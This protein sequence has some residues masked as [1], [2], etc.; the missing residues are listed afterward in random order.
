M[1][2]PF[3]S[4]EFHIHW[5]LLVPGAIEADITLALKRAAEAVEA[6][7][8]TPSG[9]ETFE[10]TVLALE[11]ALLELNRA[12]AKVEHINSVNNTP[13][14]REVHARMLPQ[15]S[16]FAT[17]VLLNAGVWRA[18]TAFA[19]SPRAASLDAPS[20]RL[21]EETLACF[22]NNGANLPAAAKERLA[23]IN[24][25]LARLTQQYAENVLDATNA[26]AKTV[27]DEALLAGLPE[28]AKAAALAEAAA[29]GETR[30]WRFTLRAPSLV[31]VLQYA[32]DETFRRECWEASANVAN[33]GANDNTRLV[34]QILDLR[35][36]KARLLGKENFADFTTV[37]RMA[38]S[39][40]NALRFV[41][42]LH[43]RVRK[44][45]ER[46]T[47][48]LENFKAAKTATPAAPLAPWEITYWAEKQRREEH[49]FD[50]EA[51]RPYLPLDDVTRGMFTLFGQLFGIRISPR[52]T[53]FTDPDTG[54]REI[55]SAGESDAA[56]SPVETWHP[57]VK[58]YEAFDSSDG[59]H[60]GSFYT[61]WHPRET[62][63]AGAWM[64]FFPTEGICHDGAPAPRL[65]LMCGNF[66]PP[67]DNAQ[68]LLSHDE[69]LTLF[70]EFGH[71]LHHILSTVPFESLGGT[72]V[73]WDFVELPSQLLE[74]WCWH[75]EGLNHFARHH[76]TGEPLPEELLKA[77][78]RASNFRAASATMRQLSL[79]KL[80]L[81]LHIHLAQ[82]RGRD[83]D[84]IWNNY[85][86][87]YQIRTSVPTPSMARRFTHIFGDPT[88]YAAGYYSYKW[89]E[90][91]EAD[92]FTR[93]LKEGLLNK[94][95]GRELREKIYS[96]GNLEPPEKLFRDFM[97]RD[98]DPQSLLIR[99]GLA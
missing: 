49:A 12:W 89:A 97:G 16:V 43:E 68:P 73:A 55:F 59:R 74:N 10:N 34:W 35:D 87:A 79:G 25:E 63:R 15:V 85:L 80:D 32:Q 42:D 76:K 77:L 45:F 90:V 2:N 92:V 22:V 51:L 65:G 50:G 61:D 60:L 27:T 48:A 3:L 23:Q 82:L 5:S 84:D 24:A 62:K 75:K 9:T 39:G 96:K 71:L 18:L 72:N 64:N 69:A 30:A 47:A 58:F 94:N 40:A 95:V 86:A 83:L 19:A 38:K 53:V 1:S 36:E 57:E 41:E 13:A 8:A 29:A 52:A 20:R 98:P 37:Q 56:A 21:L 88:G 66:T 31:P 93:F 4:S 91:L 33:G 78:T 44:H 28:N 26:W 54:Q 11:N 46:E 7:A 6:V 14:F 81:D 99:D 70:H 67:L 17:G